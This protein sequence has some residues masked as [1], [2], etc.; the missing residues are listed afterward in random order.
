[1]N[2]FLDVMCFQF[3]SSLA[4]YVVTVNEKGDIVPIN[5]KL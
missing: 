4:T 5:L 3:K 2:A 1:M